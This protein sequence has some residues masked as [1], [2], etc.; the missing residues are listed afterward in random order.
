[1][2]ESNA[3]GFG[4]Q[5]QDINPK[6]ACGNAAL[7]DDRRGQQAIDRAASR[8]IKLISEVDNYPLSRIRAAAD[9]APSTMK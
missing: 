2:P 7:A 6:G 8:L 4:W 3:V 9:F 1:M 5:M